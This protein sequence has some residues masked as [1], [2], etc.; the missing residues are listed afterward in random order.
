MKRI[1]CLVLLLSFYA[2]AA[3]GET[4]KETPFTELG[5]NG[6]QV[7]GTNQVDCTQVYFN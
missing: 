3:A 5:F 6:F 7:E 1:A 2:A 4:L